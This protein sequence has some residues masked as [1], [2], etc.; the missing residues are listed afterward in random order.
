VPKI[1]PKNVMLAAQDSEIRQFVAAE[2]STPNVITM[3][4]FK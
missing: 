4:F 2:L 3:K 1:R